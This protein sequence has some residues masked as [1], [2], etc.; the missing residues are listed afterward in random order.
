MTRLPAP[1]QHHAAPYWRVHA[2]DPARRL[3]PA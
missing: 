2:P 1:D 3:H